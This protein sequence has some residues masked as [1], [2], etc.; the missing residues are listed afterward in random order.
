MAE[1]QKRTW[2]DE[3]KEL[4][5]QIKASVEQ[6]VAQGKAALCQV[7]QARFTKAYQAIVQQGFAREA[8]EPALPSGKRGRRKQSK[9]KNLLDRLSKY[10]AETLRFM[11]DFRV[12]FDNNLAERDLRMMKVQQKISGCFR[13]TEGAEDFCCIRSYISTIKKQGHNL[14]EALTSVFAGKPLV[15]D[16]G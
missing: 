2:A 12:P 1:V 9:A 15:S 5:V 8:E 3:L 16:T 4:L 14:L 13:T 7:T 6:A 11:S 10:Q